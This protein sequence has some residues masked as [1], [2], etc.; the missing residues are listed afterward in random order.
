MRR[1]WDDR[2]VKEKGDDGEGRKGRTG[3]QTFPSAKVSKI[4]F[5]ILSA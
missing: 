5:W 1:G 4:A 3:K 2:L